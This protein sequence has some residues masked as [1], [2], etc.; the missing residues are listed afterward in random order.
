MRAGELGSVHSWELV[1]AVDG[2][3][4]RLT[5]FR[6]RL[7]AA[8][9]VLPQPRHARDPKDGKTV[10][11][12][13]AAR[14]ASAATCGVMSGDRRRTDPLRRR[15]A[16]CS[17]RSSRTLLRGAKEL[18]VHTALDTSG[19]LGANVHRRDAR[20]H[21]PGAARREVRACPRPT[22]G[23]PGSELEPDAASS[24][25]RLAAR[26]TEPRCGSASC[27]CPGLTDA[28]DN[29]EAVGAVR[30]LAQ[31][32]PVG[33]HPRRGAALPPDGPRQV[34]RARHDV[35]AGRCPLAEPRAG[36]PGA[37]SVPRTRADHVLTRRPSGYVGRPQNPNHTG[38]DGAD[39]RR[40]VRKG[41]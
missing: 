36:R 35:R 19:F 26:G 18:G 32:D 31:R 37:G 6:Q 40:V 34:G 30:R 27:S 11:R 20:R 23:S 38:T 4:T 41:L 13:G 17:P 1:T 21:R 14:A 8:V 9:P 16:A 12:R 22:G 7:P 10:D 3:G 2:P 5:V 39:G 28:V 33:R 25:D 24:A 29:V 15:A